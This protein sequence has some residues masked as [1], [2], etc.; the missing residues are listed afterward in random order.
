MLELNDLASEHGVLKKSPEIKVLGMLWNTN[1]STM[2]L[3]AKQKWS[4]KYCR[5]AVLSYA[6]QHYDPLGII[7]PVEIRMRVFL[8]ELCSLN[9]N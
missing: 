9:L 1:S 6:N 3:Q 5:R 7:V 4:G 2:T 8:Q